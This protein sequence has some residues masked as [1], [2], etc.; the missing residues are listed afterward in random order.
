MPPQHDAHLT[1]GETRGLLAYFGLDF[2]RDSPLWGLPEDAPADPRT[3]A[4]KHLLAREWRQAI[5]A[6]ASPDR[7]VRL[8]VAYP[9]QIGGMSFYG[10]G[11]GDGLVGCW[12]EEGRIRI[13]FP[14]TADALVRQACRLLAAD[15][16][17][18]MDAFEAELSPGGLAWLAAA[19]DVLRQHLLRGMLERSSAAE[20]L[21]TRQALEQVYLDGRQSADARWLVTLLGLLAPPAAPLPDALDDAAL[22]ELADAG[23]VR[24]EGGS[25]LATETLCRLAAYWITPLPALAHQAIRLDGQEPA[26][27]QYRIALRGA[28]PLW[29][30]DFWRDEQRGPRVALLSVLGSAYRATLQAMMH[31]VTGRPAQDARPAPPAP[32][33]APAAA[34]PPAL[35]AGH[36]CSA[37]GAPLAGGARFCTQCGHA[38]Q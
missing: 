9:H 15:F 30:L 35:P 37:C 23:L 7:V 36:F 34:R 33:P 20:V 6:L 10:R 26:V 14:R 17:A 18:Q 24:R 32:A 19:V 2:T 28:G 8:L 22:G 1:P 4:E 25:L 5:G 16:P 27:S 21:L 12:A 29:L 11:D 3:L 13:S 31:A 38:A